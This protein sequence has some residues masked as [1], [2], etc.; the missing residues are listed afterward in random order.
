[1]MRMSQHIMHHARSYYSEALHLARQRLKL[2]GDAAYWAVRLALLRVALRERQ[3]LL[4]TGLLIVAVALGL[5]ACTLVA[6]HVVKHATMDLRQ[7][8][9]TPRL[10]S[11]GP[12]RQDTPLPPQNPGPIGDGGDFE[13]SDVGNEEAIRPLLEEQ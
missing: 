4:L 2:P 9:S 13:D 5:S 7:L 10:A 11:R 3:R 1:M 12:Y 6:F 8:A